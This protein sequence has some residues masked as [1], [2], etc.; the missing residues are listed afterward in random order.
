MRGFVAPVEDVYDMEAVVAANT[1]VINT[2]LDTAMWNPV[3]YCVY[4]GHLEILNALYQ[5]LG[6]GLTLCFRRAQAKNE[7]EAVREQ[8]GYFEDEVYPLQIALVR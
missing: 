6:T 3:H 7:G 2:T 8:S 1:G 5:S 4:R